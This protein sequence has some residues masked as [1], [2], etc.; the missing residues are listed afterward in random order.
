MIRGSAWRCAGAGCHAGEQKAKQFKDYGMAGIGRAMRLNIHLC[1][2]CKRGKLRV[3]NYET[4]LPG[5]VTRRVRCRNPS[6]AATYK[7]TLSGEVKAG[8]LVEVRPRRGSKRVSR[9]RSARRRKA[10]TTPPA[11]QQGRAP[12]A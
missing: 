1:P 9:S 12:A 10:A 8:P 6:C 3:Y 5:H 7:Q 11:T 4:V 2:A